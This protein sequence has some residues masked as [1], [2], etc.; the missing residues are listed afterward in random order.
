MKTEDRT[1]KAFISPEYVNKWLR[2]G[3]DPMPASTTTRDVFWNRGPGN[4]WT[5]DDFRPLNHCSCQIIKLNTRQQ[6]S[7]HVPYQ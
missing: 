2:M 4:A 7:L 3:F 1:I 5:Q 6:L